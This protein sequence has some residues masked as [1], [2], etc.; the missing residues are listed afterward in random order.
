MLLCLCA[1][2][3]V[4]ACTRCVC[5]ECVLQQNKYT[6]AAQ[7]QHSSSTAAAQQQ[8]HSSNSSATAA[9]FQAL[10][11]VPVITVYV[12]G[13]CTAGDRSTTTFSRPT[14]QSSTHRRTSYPVY[15]AR[16]SSSENSSSYW[17]I[18]LERRCPPLSTCDANG[19]SRKPHLEGEPCSIQ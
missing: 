11:F 14:Q 17:Y 4:S 1:R 6:A 18:S 12:C 2:L 19:I 5:M 7:Q 9:V 15:E 13:S 8:Q 16:S 10:A 3:R